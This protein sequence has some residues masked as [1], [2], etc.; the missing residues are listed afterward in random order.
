MAPPG[1]GVVIP[2]RAFTRGKS[3]LAER[4]G[5]PERA[6]LLQAMA[7]RVVEA[8]AE[9]PVV[10]VSGAPEVLAWAS[11][12]GVEVLADP[13]SLDAAAT[14][15]VEHHR[16]RGLARV[17]VVH[18]DLP[19]VETLAPLAEPGDA[20]VAV[21]VPCHRNDGTPALSVPAGAGFR[22]SYG[23]GSFRRHVEEA[24]H[25][26][27]EVHELLD[28]QLRLDVDCVEDLDLAFGRR[29]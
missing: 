1:T 11:A 19:L 25:R 2:I 14:Q 7:E 9:L 5:E 12:R 23:P 22:F 18:A 4:L 28:P 16:A 15:G 8:A 24:H 10:V 27:L 3:R 21:L 13:G 6:G 29:R 17:A 20:P 26:G